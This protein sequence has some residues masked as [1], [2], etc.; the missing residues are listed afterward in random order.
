MKI[1]LAAMR[2]NAELNQKHVAKAVGSHPATLRKWEKGIVSPTFDQ[3][4]KLCNLYGCTVDDL[5]FSTKSVI[6]DTEVRT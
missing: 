1:S 4:M 5:N 6:F 3:T 2:A